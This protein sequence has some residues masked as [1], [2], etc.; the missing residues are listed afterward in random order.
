MMSTRE[1][2]LDIRVV[3]VRYGTHTVVRDASLGVEAGAMTAVLGPSGSGKSS[4]LRAVAGLETPA[5]G[6]VAIDGVDVTATPPHERGI[7]MMFQSGALF[8]HYSV[9]GNVAYALSRG[10]FRVPRAQRK[11]RVEELLDLVGL[12][13]FASRPPAS[14]SGG[15]AQRVAL[16]RALASHPRVLLL[17][18]P[19][20]ALDRSLREHLALE[21]RRIVTSQGIGGLY[22]THDQDEAFSVADRL[23]I[24]I[25]GRIRREGGTRE[26]WE[27]P[28]E[29]DVAAFLGYDPIVP[30]DIA[31]TWGVSG[32]AQHALALAPGALRLAEDAARPLVIDAEVVSITD[33]RGARDVCVDI[34]GIG[35]ARVRAPM[36]WHPRGS[37][38][39]LRLDDDQVAWVR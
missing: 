11:H 24:L 37:V 8:D 9:G 33:V 17:D 30:A 4:L 20:S 32:P 36:R 7:G 28:R 18:E 25:D 5:G 38:L 15:Q 1:P 27:D 34:A 22:V 10:R 39:P 12:R 2:R 13:G 35:R 16:A 21:I 19:L 29:A 23:A 3:S 26:V 31:A 14:L 6:R